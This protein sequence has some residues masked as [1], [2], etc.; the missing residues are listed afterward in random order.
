[1]L[2]GEG[3]VAVLR[4]H[5]GGAAGGQG[6]LALVGLPVDAVVFRV[7]AGV[8]GRQQAVFLIG[9]EKVLPQ[10]GH[11][12][13]D[14]RA[15][16][17][18]PVEPHAQGEEHGQEN[19]ED[20]GGAAQVGGDH[21]NGA[22]DQDE[23]PRHHGHRGEGIDVPV[24]LEPG[25][26]LGGD[27]DVDDLDDLGGLDADAGEADPGPVAG[28]VVLA[29]DAQGDQQRDLDADQELPLSRQ[30][31]RVDHREEHIG[32]DAQEHGEDLHDDLLVGIHLPAGGHHAG[33][34]TVDHHRAENGA[35]HADDEHRDVRPL[36]E[37]LDIRL[38]LLYRKHSLSREMTIRQIV[39]RILSQFSSLRNGHFGGILRKDYNK[40]VNYGGSVRCRL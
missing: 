34:G 12:G 28:A 8:I 15:A 23:V 33:G 11:H 37:L 39:K 21:N 40:C 25:H 5:A 1:M 7:D 32:A 14:G 36:P 13:G 30:Q 6:D 9:L 20:D 17:S 3:G 4:V 26:L 19:A 27:D 16:Q 2:A 38:Q 35:D 29:Q 24:L 18:E 31:I 10:Q 22:E